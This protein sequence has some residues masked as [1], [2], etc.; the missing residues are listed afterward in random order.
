[1]AN[2][3][4]LDAHP[5]LA[6]H[7]AKLR[8]LGYQTTEEVQGA[9]ASAQELMAR[10]LDEDLSA[11]LP[12]PA[13]AYAA[14][15][16]HDFPL[17]VTLD[18]IP[19]PTFAFAMAAP[20]AGPLPASVNLIPNMPAIRDQAHRGTC[21]AHA[22]LA[23]L[24]NLRTAGGTFRGMSEQFLYFN[25]K[26]NDGIPT[27]AGTFLGIAVPL[28]QRD[29]CCLETTWP[30][31]PNPVAGNEGQGPPPT[32]AV[33]QATTMRIASHLQL[34]PTA[35]I[36]FKRELARGR[37]IAFSIPVFNSWYQNAAVRSSGDIVLPFPNETVVGG[38]AMCICG[39]EDNAAEAAI[40]GGRFTL[41]NSWDSAWG[42]AC[43]FGV[44][45]GTIPYAYISRFG[46][47]A[48][49]IE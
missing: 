20:T 9:L 43:R 41:R 39:Y 19:A 10:Y 22:A 14:A 5:V 15:A 30:Y 3:D 24:E 23:A 16:A 8:A 12:K 29:G 38:H 31:N 47:E 35:V 32:N 49:S 21:V 28:L 34:A 6:R 11:Q 13:A 26:R 44:G 25:C 4:S 18:A 27:A 36:D 40:G 42:T 17:G 33:A 7:A 2:G 46:K 45:Y 37:C 48:Y 1:M